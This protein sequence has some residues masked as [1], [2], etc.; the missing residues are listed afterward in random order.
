MK[1]LYVVQQG[2]HLARDGEAVVVMVADEKIEKV[3]PHSISQCVV[4][5]NV[6]V[7]TPA[8][9][10]LL[11]QGVDVVFTSRT[12]RFVG[13]LSSGLSRNIELRMAQ[14]RLLTDPDFALR[15]S[16][17]IVAGKIENQ[18][19]L[20][21]RYQKRRKTP[22]IA[23]A[24]AALRRSSLQVELA[25]DLDTLRG[26]EGF[27]AAAYFSAWPDLLENADFGFE[28]RNRRPPRDPI[29][30]LLSFGYTLLGNLYHSLI[31]AT[32]LDPFLGALHAPRYGRPSLVLDLIEEMRPVIVDTAAL[33][34]AN[35]KTIRASDFEKAEAADASIEEAWE[36]E[37]YEEDSET[38]ATPPPR[39]PLIFLRPG[40]KKWLTAYERRLHERSRYEP[41][42]ASLELEDIARAQ[43]HLLARHL[44]GEE[45]YTPFL[46]PI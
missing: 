38:G 45:T 9:R 5:G 44:R 21:R 13:R 26:V 18:R 19:R 11:A 29:N 7:S 46:S 28:K 15:L 33:R 10:S 4:M 42:D 17:R 35:T 8:V 36:A 31:E 27:A 43:V 3:D 12:G 39:R 24:L 20:L 40:V 2:A 14:H 25:E 1:T 34:A 32:G 23:A 22:K 16:C 6:G 37:E 30:V 41:R